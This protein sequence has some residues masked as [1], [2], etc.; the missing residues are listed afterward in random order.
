MKSRKKVL[1]LFLGIFI[2]TLLFYF[3]VSYDTYLQ[4]K[5]NP[6]T[7]E[8]AGSLFFD[9]LNSVRAVFNELILFFDVWFLMFA[10]NKNSVAKIL[11]YITMVFALVTFVYMAIVSLDD[12]LFEILLVFACSLMSLV[13]FMI[14]M[15][16]GVY[17][18][19]KAMVI[20]LRLMLSK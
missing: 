10:K 2:I 11:C 12:T 8:L 6:E 14:T 7:K 3:Y 4:Y 9:F 16:Y 19:I 1:L 17:C 18:V 20:K 15:F 13:N 5:D